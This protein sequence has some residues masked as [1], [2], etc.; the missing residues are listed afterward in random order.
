MAKQKE[1]FINGC[2]EVGGFEKEQSVAL[3]EMIETFAA[4][5]FNKA[6]AASYGRIAY[7]TSYLKANFPA[8]YMA[9]V[10]TADQGDVEKVAE[11]INEC[12][13]MGIEILPP[14]VNESFSDFTVVDRYTGKAFD[15]KDVKIDI[16]KSETETMSIRFGLTTI[17]NFG[18]GIA[19]AIIRNRLDNGKFKSLTDFL[20]RITDKNLNKKSLEA[21]IKSGAL[22]SLGKRSDMM[23]NLE[24]LLKY[25]KDV[26]KTDSNQASLFDGTES[27]GNLTLE[28]SEPLS[29]EQ[30]LA[31]ESF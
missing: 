11:M 20:E 6:H 4:Y 22:D 21:L 12:K 16:S 9:A 25:N 23:Y 8:V 27:T 1:K 7:L 18:E 13:R 26:A 14:D 28:Q 2:V 15:S 29:T 5:G 24:G 10:L 3:W 31:W 19:T 17:K 30:K